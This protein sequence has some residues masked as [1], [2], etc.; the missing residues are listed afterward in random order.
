[1]FQLDYFWYCIENRLWKNKGKSRGLLET[2][3]VISHELWWWFTSSDS[4]HGCDGAVGSEDG[5]N[6]EYILNWDFSGGSDGKIAICNAGDLGSI[7][8][9]GKSPGEVNGNPVQY[10]CLENS[11]DEGA[12][13]QSMG[14]QWAGHDWATNI[15]PVTFKRAIIKLWKFPV[16][17]LGCGLQRYWRR[18]WHPTPVFLPGKFHGQRS[19]VGCSP[20]SLEESDTTEWLHFHFSL[21]GIGEGNGD[22]LQ[23]SCL[24]NP[25]DGGAWWA[26]VCGVAESRTWLKQL[27]SSSSIHIQTFT[28]DLGTT[29]DHTLISKKQK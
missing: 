13:L 12:K 26:A 18:R 15:F 17:S 9:S 28:E 4:G 19:L 23:C 10:S 8:G 22:P 14:L 6:F 2:T 7:C 16:S 27:S 20:W 11:M 21:S 25:R 1:M 24:E 29:L 3:A 5:R